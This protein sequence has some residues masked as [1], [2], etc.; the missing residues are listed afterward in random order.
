VLMLPWFDGVAMHDDSPV[1]GAL[2]RHMYGAA[3]RIATLAPHI[4]G[5]S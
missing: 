1:S 4:G 5:G 2:G 3:S